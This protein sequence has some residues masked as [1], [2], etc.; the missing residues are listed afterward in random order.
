MFTH[1]LVLCLVTLLTLV[2]HAAP[3]NVVRME[4]VVRGGSEPIP[5]AYVMVRGIRR[6]GVWETRS[7]ANGTITL[8]VGVGCYHL[9]ASAEG[10]YPYVKRFCVDRESDTPKLSLKLKRDPLRYGTLS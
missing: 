9:F 2:G 1:V 4:A 5:N 10:Y 8:N 3:K 6:E 7:D